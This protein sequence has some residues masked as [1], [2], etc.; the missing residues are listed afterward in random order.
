[1]KSRRLAEPSRL[2]VTSSGRR[3]RTWNPGAELRA[4]DLPSVQ[5]SQACESSTSP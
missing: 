3:E 4:A 5:V 1:M 2:Q